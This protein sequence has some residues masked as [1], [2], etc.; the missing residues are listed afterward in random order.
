MSFGILRTHKLRLKVPPSKSSAKCR[1]MSFEIL[2]TH[3]LRLRTIKGSRGG[4][5]KVIKHKNQHG[6]HPS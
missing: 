5:E 2:S 6:Y 3:K 4:V 1:K